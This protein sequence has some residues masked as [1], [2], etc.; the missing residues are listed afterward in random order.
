MTNNRQK[1]NL[2]IISASIICFLGTI[3]IPIKALAIGSLEAG[4]L[5][6]R[7]DSQPE[8]IFGLDGV[9]TTISNTLLYIIGALSVLMIII[10]GIKYVLS[11]GKEAS[12]AKARN[13]ILYA[14]IGLVITLLA[15]AIVNFVI[16]SLV[17]SLG[18]GASI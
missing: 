8:S 17:P 4:V 14:I 3:F 1:T 18:G 7:T 13:T 9:F 2:K 16:E 6:A 15:Y 12:V 5:A 11:G 10:G